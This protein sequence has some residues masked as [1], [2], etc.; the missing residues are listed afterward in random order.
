VERGYSAH[1]ISAYESDLDQFQKA[2]LKDLLL[3][4]TDD[5]RKFILSFLAKTDLLIRI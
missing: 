4:T 2:L 3:G 1:T 5:I